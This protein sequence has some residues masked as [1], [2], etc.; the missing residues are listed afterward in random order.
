MGSWELGVWRQFYES[1]GF[2]ADRIEG[3]SAMSGAA[4]CNSWGGKVEPNDLIPRF[5]DESTA[6]SKQA[7]NEAFV[8]YMRARGAQ[9]EFIPNGK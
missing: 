4:I 6:A 1:H 9:V 7:E 2:D 3:A 8:A 5:S